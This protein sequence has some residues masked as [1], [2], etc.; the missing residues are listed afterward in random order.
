VAQKFAILI[1]E[2]WPDLHMCCGFGSLLASQFQT[3]STAIASARGLTSLCTDI[4]A[5]FKPGQDSSAQLPQAF[6]RDIA[7]KT[8][9]LTGLAP[10]H[11]PRHRTGSIKHTIQRDMLLVSTRHRVPFCCRRRGHVMWGLAK[12]WLEVKSR[13]RLGSVPSDKSA[14]SNVRP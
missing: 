4:G 2:E 11:H 1:E 9:D 10:S 3:S 5:R 8:K 7:T 12:A 13:L 14:V 6:I